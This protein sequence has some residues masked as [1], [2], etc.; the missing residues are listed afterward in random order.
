MFGDRT[1]GLQEQKASV[2]DLL[3]SIAGQHAP[4][5]VDVVA[6][7]AAPPHSSAEFAHGMR[8]S[9]VMFVNNIS[10]WEN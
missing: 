4:S 7:I 1:F 2:E 8:P 6:A 3:A 5:T 9:F 10:V